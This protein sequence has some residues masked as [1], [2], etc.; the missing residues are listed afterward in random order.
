MDKSRPAYPEVPDEQARVLAL[1]RY[2]VLDTAPEESF[3][4]I[5]RLAK[6]TLGVPIAL[7][8]LVDRDRQWLKANEGLSVRET[9]RDVSF[10]T[11]AICQDVPMLVMDATADAR[12]RD[13]P[14]VTGDPSI[15][16]YLGAP[17]HTHDGHNIGTLCAIDIVPRMPTDEQVGILQDLA[18]LV[19]NELELRQLATIDSLTGAMTRRYF[20]AQADRA[21]AVARRYAHPAAAIMLDIDHFKRINDRHGHPAGDLVLQHVVT[22]IRTALREVDL[23]GRIGGEEF[24]VVLPETTQEGARLTAERLRAAIAARP[25]RYGDAAIEVTASLGVAGLEPGDRDA[26]GL[27]GRADAGLYRAKHDGRNRVVVVVEA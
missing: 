11:H 9:P 2:A 15:R 14:L 6:A 18:R 27:L 12:F 16:F 8:S 25:F 7:I 17:L 13:N 4:R 10:C 1:H 26:A 22:T 20:F 5:A 19:M 23:L 21:L 24:A 3:D